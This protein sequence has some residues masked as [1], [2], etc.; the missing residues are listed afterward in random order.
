MLYPIPGYEGLYSV[1]E[2]GMVYGHKRQKFLGL[3]Y[4]RCGYVRYILWREGKPKEHPAHRIVARVFHGD[5]VSPANLALH[6]D[7]DKTNNHKDNIR[8]G[9]PLD[10]ML[11]KVAHGRSN[12]DRQQCVNGHDYQPEN[13]YINPKDGSK[14]CRIC[15]RLASKKAYAKRKE[16]SND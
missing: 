3:R 15:R 1:T 7:G 4:G 10:N 11:D 9:T 2:D 14:S 5:P 16:N 13:T 8:W 12:R 6:N